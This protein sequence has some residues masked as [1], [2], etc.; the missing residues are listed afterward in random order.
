MCGRTSD[1]EIGRLSQERIGISGEAD[2][3]FG[4]GVVFG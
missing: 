4:G 2:G 3:S 1:Q